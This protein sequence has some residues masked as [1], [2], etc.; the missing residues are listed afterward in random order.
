[1][2]VSAFLSASLEAS[3]NVRR[4]IKNPSSKFCDPA[5]EIW[6]FDI[7]HCA[8]QAPLSVFDEFHMRSGR[9]GKTDKSPKSPFEIIR[10]AVKHA[11]IDVGVPAFSV[12]NFQHLACH[13]RK[14]CNFDDETSKIKI[15][16][17]RTRAVEIDKPNLVVTRRS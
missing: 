14:L 7:E 15:G 9:I 2:A 17:M 11:P 4:D 10:N 12:V 5:I 3:P 1:M 16:I 6:T 13:I 8:Q